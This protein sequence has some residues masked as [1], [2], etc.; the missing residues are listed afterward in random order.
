MTF[1]IH[2]Y[3]YGK[4]KFQTT[5]QLWSLYV[6]QLNTWLSHVL[7]L[8]SGIFRTTPGGNGNPSPIVTE[9]TLKLV[10]A[11]HPGRNI[12]KIPGR[13]FNNTDLWHKGRCILQKVRLTMSINRWFSWIFTCYCKSIFPK[14]NL[15]G[16][17][18][19]QARISPPF[20][21]GRFFF[22]SAAH[23][24]VNGRWMRTRAN[25]SGT[26]AWC[27]PWVLIPDLTREKSPFLIGKPRESELCC[28]LNPDFMCTNEKRP[29][30]KQNLF[31][32]S[33]LMV[34]TQNNMLII[35][36]S[37]SE[38]GNRKKNNDITS[39]IIILYPP[40][41]YPYCITILDDIAIWLF[42]IAMERST[43]F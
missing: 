24:L 11:H 6:S 1:P 40:T 7:L 18:W 38:M 3:I 9:L 8:K 37:S 15:H 12:G 29:W 28:W 26:R 14:C 41:S 31:E 17:S 20:A 43:H 16:S 39:Q 4:K 27:V 32:Y 33:I 42:N 36:G 35:G 19:L 30:T 13:S 22:L 5:N 21:P 2:I 23:G 34:S 10:V 25:L